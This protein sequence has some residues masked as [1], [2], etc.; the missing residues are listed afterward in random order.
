MF[1]ATVGGVFRTTDEG[2]TW[3][4]FKQTGWTHSLAVDG[5]HIYGGLSSHLAFSYNDGADWDEVAFFI[6]NPIVQGFVLALEMIGD[7]LFAG[8][9]HGGVL[10]IRNPNPSLW[11]FQTTLIGDTTVHTLYA[12][13]NDLYA[14]TEDGLYRM[15]ADGIHWDD[16]NTG[17][18]NRT[19][20]AILKDGSTLYAGTFGG[21]VFR[22]TNNGQSWTPINNG[23]TNLDVLSFAVS[24]NTLF[25]GTWNYGV[26][27]TT[28]QGMNW[29]EV[30]DGLMNNVKQTFATVHDLV[31]DGSTLYAG[32]RHTG[33]WERPIAEMTTNVNDQP[34]EKPDRLILGQNYPN[35]FNAS[36][37]IQYTITTSSHVKLT[38]YDLLGKELAV[39]IDE[40]KYSGTY[41]VDWSAN[42]L[43]TGVYLYR[44]EAGRSIKTRKLII[45][46]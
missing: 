37:R 23:L 19:V 10:R 30:N 11:T 3:E 31:V 39:L 33:V 13:G 42:D 17:L 38:V 32:T 44:L 29:S 9:V 12:D 18:T 8:M 28:D 43:S 20:M 34:V 4:R 41:S 6:D 36:T 7:T 45:Q 1:A 2:E 46:K 16:L 22:S 14:G 26:F 24:G 40:Y 35:P 21:G 15:A 5:N 25:A 27:M